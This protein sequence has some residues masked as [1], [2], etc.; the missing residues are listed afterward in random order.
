MNFIL[1]VVPT[2]RRSYRDLS[3][4]AEPVEHVLEQYKRKPIYFDSA[5]VYIWQCTLEQD[6]YNE[7]GDLGP[8]ANI[9]FVSLEK[10]TF[11]LIVS[12]YEIVTDSFGTKFNQWSISALDLTEERKNANKFFSDNSVATF[13]EGT[14]VFYKE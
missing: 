4:G 7:I 3:T 10:E 1:T 9:F 12:P 14:R 2:S 5:I 11:L 8:K 13:V 6:G